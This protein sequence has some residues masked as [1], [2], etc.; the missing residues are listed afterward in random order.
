MKKYFGHVLTKIIV[1]KLIYND[2]VIIKP[3]NKNTFTG[4]KAKRSGFWQ[5][6]SLRL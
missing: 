2:T 6:H 5:G 3:N 4:F 1:L